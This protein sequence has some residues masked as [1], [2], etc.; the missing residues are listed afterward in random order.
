MEVKKYSYRKKSNE[1]FE[2]NPLNVI[3][4][5]SQG[6]ARKLIIQFLLPFGWRNF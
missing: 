5:D 2:S 4:R 1:H 6:K 3:L